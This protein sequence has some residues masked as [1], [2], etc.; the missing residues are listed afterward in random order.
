MNDILIL[1]VTKYLKREY[2]CH[3]IILY[4]SYTTENFTEESDLDI[5]CFT[6]EPRIQNDNQF[7]HDVQLDA[8]I[9]STQDMK[10]AAKYL[11]IRDGIL[12]FDE[13]NL[14]EVLL[15]EV[16][17]IYRNGPQHIDESEIKFLKDWLRKM[18]NRSVKGDVEGNF[19]YHWL[20]NDSLEIYFKIIHQW[21]LGPKKSLQWLQA[22]DPRA[23]Q[24]FSGALSR[25]AS[26]ADIEDLIRHI[27][28]KW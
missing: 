5:I 24:L 15:E 20:L 11:H 16:D 7:I 9:Y 2:G 22:N 28:G 6:D 1:D 13:R 18:L 23:F 3:S 27:T 21:Y 17:K 8:W 19:R 25:T 12:L 14:G 26:T 10:E 4:G